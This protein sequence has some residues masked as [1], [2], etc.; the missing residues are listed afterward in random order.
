M[1]KI[2]EFLLL[3]IMAL[4]SAILFS[5]AVIWKFFQ[6]MFQIVFALITPEQTRV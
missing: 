4:G 6:A 2:F 5:L 1:D 3:I